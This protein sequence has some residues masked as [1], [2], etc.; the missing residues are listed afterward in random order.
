M[1]FPTAAARTE[2]LRAKR[3]SLTSSGW[4]NRSSCPV[5]TL[6]TITSRREAAA[7]NFPSHLKSV[8]LPLK[9]QRGAEVTALD[10]SHTPTKPFSVPNAT[11]AP[12][13]L[14]ATD[15]TFPGAFKTAE[16]EFPL[17]AS[18]ICAV[19]PEVVTNCSPLESIAIAE[20]SKKECSNP[21]KSRKG[22]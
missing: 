14:N 22:Q 7:A 4:D 16:S 21:K 12:F 5:S 8:E 17:T 19:R 6:I 3:T 9:D 18:L 1:A 13:G 11:R 20:T 2:P 15:C 10:Q